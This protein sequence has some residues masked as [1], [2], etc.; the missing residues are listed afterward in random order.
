MNLTYYMSNMYK[1]LTNYMLTIFASF[2]VLEFF[3][4]CCYTKGDI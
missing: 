4:I 3:V 2:N 1:L